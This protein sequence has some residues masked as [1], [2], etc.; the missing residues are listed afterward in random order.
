MAN[1]F[2]LEGKNAWITGASYGIGFNI[3][4]AFVAAGIKN[5]IFNDI[6]EA[7]LERGLANY[8]EAGITNVHGY[9]CDVTD[10][11]A[12]KALVEKIHAEVGQIDI[13]VNNAGIIKR[14]P[15]HEMKRQEFQ[16]VIDV[17]LVAPFIV[18]SAVIPEMMERKEGK[19][20][21]KM[22]TR[23]ICSEYGEYNIQC[24]G[25]GPGYIATPQTAPLREKQPDGSRHPFDSFICAKTPAGRWLEPEELG[26]P[27]VFL[28]SHASDAVNGHILYVDGGILAYIGK[29][30]K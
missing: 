14:I 4:K 10:E 17:D 22:L 3:A 21:L 6:N 25:I 30:P 24:N 27:A 20:G 2:S 18:A 8:K 7:A 12:V 1:P 13:L 23:N 11:N 29:Q 5:I 26:G 16:Q 15:M 28:A 19:G 9:V